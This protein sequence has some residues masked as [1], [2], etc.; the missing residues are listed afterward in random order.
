MAMQR[1]SLSQLIQRGQDDLNLRL[2]GADS[3]LRQSALDVM[4]K[5][6][7]GAVHGVYGYI[8]QLARQILPDTADGQYLESHASSKGIDR[9]P[10]TLAA[11]VATA[12]GVDGSVIPAGAV[13]QRPGGREYQVQGDVVI[14]GG[15]ATVPLAATTPGVGGVAA[16]GVKLA[17]VSPIAG[18]AANVTVAG[19]GLTGGADAESDDLLRGRLLERLR[20]TPEGGALHDYI[21][22]AKAVP[23]VTRAWSY[24]ARMGAGTVGVAFMMDGRPNPIPTED[25]VEAVQ[26]YMELVAPAPGETVVFAPI[27]EPL[28]LTIG[29]LQ[30]N[31]AATRAAIEAEIDDL[32]FREARPDGTIL[33]SHIRE[34][35]ST[36][37]G[38]NDHVLLSPTDNVTHTAGKIAVRGDIIWAP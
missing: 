34:A 10:A 18:V 9:K 6:N 21:A 15:V 11:G 23:E 17:F 19:A 16:V 2:P 37:A 22:W 33:L 38:E 31:D 36:A 26:A 12:T 25:D 29:G 13:L 20:Q 14:A 4:V 27:P 8:D 5:V 7:A 30:P 32:L 3:R 28:N 35:I 24:K 1:P